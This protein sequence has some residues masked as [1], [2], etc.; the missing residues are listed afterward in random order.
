MKELW[1]LS[2]IRYELDDRILL[3][4]ADVCIR[5]KEIIGIIGENGAGKTTLLSLIHGDLEPV[6]GNIQRISPGLKAVM[7]EQETKSPPPIST[8]PFEAKLLEEWQVPSHSFHAL[9]GGEKRKAQLA[10]GLASGADLLLL[11]EPTNHLDEKGM[12]TLICQL[13]KFNGAIILVSHDRYFLDKTATKIWA[14][15]DKKIVEH[16]GNYS[17]Y[18]A[19]RKQ[20]RRSLQQAYEKQQKRMEQTQKQIQDLSSWSKKAHAQSTKQEGMKEYYRV[21]AKRMDA[22]I[23]SKKKRLEKEIEKA[24]I[25]QPQSEHA[26][27]FTLT[28]NQKTGRRFAEFKKVTKSFN[29]RTLFQDVNFTI[30]HGERVA[31]S[32]PNGSGKTTLL[33]ILMGKEPAKGDVWLSPSANIGYLTQEMLDLPL[34]QTPEQLFYQETFQERGKV[35]TL[36]D[37]L[38]F[39]AS[40]W[41]EPI[42]NMSMGERVKCK[43]M[44]FILEEKDTLIL[45]EPTNHLDLASREQLEDTLTEY[46]GTL[47][48]VS[49]DRYFTEKTTNTRLVISGRNILKEDNEAPDKKNDHEERKWVLET[50]RQEVLG[51][52]SFLTPNHPAYPELDKKFIEL[53]KQIRDLT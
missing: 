39:T 53:T 23:K 51:K 20:K 24:N 49:H 15:E 6:T 2:K 14:I 45:D 32:G 31:V 16:T 47:L 19:D 7:V 25:Q 36:M 18:M 33:N 52:L 3:E 10:R 46:T 41:R 34:D 5:E 17:S 9:S 1:K 43:L 27:H 50:E 4:E 21:K 26:V 28:T 12:E 48:L 35:Q 37:Q 42:G 13:K 40:Q 8:S 44:G 11:D 29:G 22:Q 38:G 30:Q